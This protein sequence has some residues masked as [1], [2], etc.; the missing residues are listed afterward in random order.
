MCS[1]DGVYLGMLWVFVP[2]GKSADR[3]V[4]WLECEISRHGVGSVCCLQSP[5]LF[6]W[7]DF[8]LIY[9]IWS[10]VMQSVS[11]CHPF[12]LGVACML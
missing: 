7:C 12:C 8:T 2:R 1:F 3:S 4:Q 9:V 10:I 11:T 6:S 5:L